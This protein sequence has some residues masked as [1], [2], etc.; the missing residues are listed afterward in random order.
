MVNGNYY[1]GGVVGLARGS[2]NITNCY[3]T[4]TVSGYDRIGGVVGEI[5]DG[6]VVAN[7]YSAGSIN[8]K[9]SGG[10]GIKY[11][12]GVV[13]S[14]TDPITLGSM[15]ITDGG[16]E[17]SVT[18]CAALNSK[19]FVN[20]L[21]YC[22]YILYFTGG[23]YVRRVIAEIHVRSALLDNVAFDGIDP[24]INAMF[25]GDRIICGGELIYPVEIWGER[26]ASTINGADI[27]AAAIRADGTIG[28]RFTPANGWTVENGKLP[29]LLGQTVELPEHLR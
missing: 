19:I 21:D 1:V 18:N 25:M 29:G 16:K 5:G 27:S 8:G 22:P 2:I 28:G 7:C 14:V 13:G 17:C 6:A 3:S 12:G 4:G 26:G 11:V 10:G 20:E 15:G 9:S 24:N 23:V